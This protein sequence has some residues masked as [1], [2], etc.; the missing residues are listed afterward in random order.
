MNAHYAMITE[1]NRVGKLFYLNE[2]DV[3]FGHDFKLITIYLGFASLALL[4]ADFSICEL[5]FA[6]IGFISKTFG[7]NYI[8]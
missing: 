4:S 8:A 1:G 6:V 3:R 2:G 5:R 7:K